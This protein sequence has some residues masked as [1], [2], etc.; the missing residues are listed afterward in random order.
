MPASLASAQRDLLRWIVAPE[1]VERALADDGCGAG[2]RLGALVQGSAALP[3]ERR[4]GVYAH[5]YF[6][7]IAGALRNDFP[8][9]ARALGAAGFHDLVKLY[10]LAHPP[11]HWSLRF[12]GERLADFARAHA[13]AAVFR[14][15]WPFAGDLA[16]LEWSILAAFDAADAEPLGREDLARV[17]VPSWGDLVLVARPGT[18]LLRLEW[19]VQRLRETAD[20]DELPVL[21]P[22]ATPVGVWRSDERVCFRGLPPDEADALEGLLA[23]EPFGA[24]CARIERHAGD[25]AARRALGLLDRWLADGVLGRGAAGA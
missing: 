2:A 8:A 25:G 7:R 10:L 20:A 5:A 9:L 18:A 12:A 4:L 6:A 22:E 24:I 19:P 23:G 17:P 11:R 15:R 1:G 3:A 21:S 14:A 13:A 16:A